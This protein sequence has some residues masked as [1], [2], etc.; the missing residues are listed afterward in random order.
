MPRT[1]INSRRQSRKQKDLD[2]KLRLAE[3]KFDAIFESVDEVERRYKQEVDN[4]I[5][6]LR[7][8]TEKQLLDMKLTDF[9]G[10]K[11]DHFDDYQFKA[12]KG[13]TTRSQSSGRMRDCTPRHTPRF[14]EQAQS[15]DRTKARGRTKSSQ[16][17]DDTLT[18]VRWPR[19]GERVLSTAGSPLAVHSQ[20]DLF[21][22]VHIPTPRGVITVKPQ[23]M[24]K[25]KRDVLMQMDTNTLNQVKTLNANLEMIVDM[26]TKMGKL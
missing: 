6:L 23:K 5:K 24:D 15:V 3:M 25:V 19:A 14:R 20:S 7:A 4:K 16:N 21:P 10:L 26:A 17:V 18:F 11:L 1:K 9:L 8:R 2:E 22:D 13:P 12:P